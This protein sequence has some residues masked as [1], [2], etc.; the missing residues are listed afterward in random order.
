MGYVPDGRANVVGMH[1]TGAS[2]TLEYA[3]QDWCLAQMAKAMGK[4]ADYELFFERSKNYK[5]LW[6]KAS[7]FMQPKGT[8]GEWLPDFDPLELTEKGGFCESNSAIYSHYVP[9]D[10]QGLIALYGGHKKYAERLN[11]NFVKSEPY[12]FSVQ[13]IPNLVIGLITVTNQARAWLIFSIMLG[14]HG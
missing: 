8:D 2:M 11:E 6:N 4:Q 3:Y 13:K 14:H 12:G 9:H 7:G 1:T 5:N 10:M